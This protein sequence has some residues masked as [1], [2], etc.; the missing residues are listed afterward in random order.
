M[1]SAGSDIEFNSGELVG[2]AVEGDLS[3][4]PLIFGGADI[5]LDLGAKSITANWRG[6]VIIRVKVALKTDASDNDT[7]IIEPTRLEMFDNEGMPVLVLGV[8]GYISTTDENG[9]TIGESMS[10]DFNSDGIV[11]I[12][13]VIS[14]LLY[15][16]A[17][18]DDLKADFNG[19]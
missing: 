3:I 13:D 8:D 4:E 5:K 7:L 19:D 16:R 9:G 17:H 1:L 15:Q 12:T 2:D 18:P 6:D 11:A 14:L 10:C